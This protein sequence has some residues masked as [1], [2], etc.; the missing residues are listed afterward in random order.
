MLWQDGPHWHAGKILVGEERY[1]L[2][3]PAD[4]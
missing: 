4:S 3:E 1:L 2:A